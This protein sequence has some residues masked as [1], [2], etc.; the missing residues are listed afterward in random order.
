MCLKS[1]ATQSIVG[2]LRW[3]TAG[4]FTFRRQHRDRRRH[5]KVD[6]PAVSRNN[7]SQTSCAA[8]LFD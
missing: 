8:I 4:T 2:M 6:S 7:L 3:N 1:A 5:L